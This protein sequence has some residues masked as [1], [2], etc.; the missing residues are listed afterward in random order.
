MMED[1]SISKSSWNLS[2]SKINLIGMLMERAVL[3]SMGL[4]S[5]GRDFLPQEDHYRALECWKKIE[6]LI[7]NRMTSKQKIKI[8]ELEKELNKKSLRLNSK[9][10]TEGGAKYVY[11]NSLL[12]IHSQK[13]INYINYLLRVHGMDIASRDTSVEDVE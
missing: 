7:K 8:K 2:Q 6:M 4:I 10:S 9:R 13:Y 11:V 1:E 5:K 12:K 3:E